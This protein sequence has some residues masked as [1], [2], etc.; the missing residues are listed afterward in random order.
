MIQFI[1]VT[2]LYSEKRVSINVSVIRDV[3]EADEGCFITTCEDVKKGFRGFWV[4]ES[5]HTV[6]A[7][8]TGKI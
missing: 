1:E 7:M 4:K 6:M 3:Q 5:Y 8:L 2:S